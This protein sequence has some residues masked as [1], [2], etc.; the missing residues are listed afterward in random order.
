[1]I[2]ASINADNVASATFASEQAAFLSGVLAAFQAAEDGYTNRVGIIAAMENDAT[3]DPMINGFIQGVE[4][5]DAEYDLNVTVLDI[6]YLDSWND[7]DGASDAAFNMFLDGDLIQPGNQPGASIIFAPV[8]AS[9]VGVR[10][11]SLRADEHRLF[12]FNPDRA[13]LIIAAEG[14]QDYY[15]CVDI[16]IPTAPSFIATSVLARTD[17]ALYDMVNMTMWDQFTGFSQ[18]YDLANGGVNITAYEYSS[19]YLSEA[20]VEA[21]RSYHDE[22]IAGTIIVT[23]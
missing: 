21:V 7:S 16:D 12:T 14:N 18:M 23:P 1:M 10:N 17:L 22:I 6:V 8:R 2:G 5:A 13:P 19:T 20:T 3:L 9:I 15:G 4:A 11:G